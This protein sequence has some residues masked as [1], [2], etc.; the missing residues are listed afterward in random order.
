MTQKGKVSDA[1]DGQAQE[2]L[3]ILGAW[4]IWRHRNRCVL[5][6]TVPRVLVPCCWPVRNYSGGVWPGLGVFPS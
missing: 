4:S 3:I 1:I 2:A 5:D 6:G